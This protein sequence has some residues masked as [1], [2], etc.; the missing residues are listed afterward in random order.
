[1]SGCESAGRHVVEG[2]ELDAVRAG[3]LE[4]DF[5]AARL[6]RVR[7]ESGGD[8]ACVAAGEKGAHAGHVA[9]SDGWVL[10]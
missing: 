3:V 1:M 4:E 2:P 7:P 9:I 5:D 8:G 6:A 10:G